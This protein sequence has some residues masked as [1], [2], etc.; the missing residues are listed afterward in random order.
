MAVKKRQPDIIL[1][2]TVLILLS[3]GIVMVFSASYYQTMEKDLFFYVRK[4][5]LWGLLSLIAMFSALKIDYTRWK[6]L[7]SPIFIIS[8]FFLILVLIPGV[9]KTIKGAT[10]WIDLGFT[11]FQ[12]SDLSKIALVMF[13]SRSLAINQNMLKHFLKGLVPYLIVLGI[14]GGLIMGEPDLGTTIALCGTAAI[15]LFAAGCRT[16]HFIFLGFLGLLA[17]VVLIMMAPYRLERIY[18][19]LFPWEYMSDEGYQTV[20]S[21]F[22]LGSGG[23]FGLGLGNS[24]QKLLYL[25]ERHTDF[26][27]A[28]I[29]EEL[30]FIGASL[31]ILLFLIFTW[32]GYKIALGCPEAFGSLLAVG[33]TSMISLQAFLNIGVV[34]GAL[35]VTGISLP[36]ISYG[37]SSLLMFMASVGILLNISRYSSA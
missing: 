24:R 6:G 1:F 4:Q 14:V 36:F 9:G 32:R 29:G 35:P 15:M 13:F 8:I 5:L 11:N 21:L 37:G 25:P 30:G 19:W 12:P 22:A 31:V 33:I 27:Y 3:I 20:Q 18:G 17:V 2:L 23:L 26:I 28:I 7:A 34:T 16:G 10:R